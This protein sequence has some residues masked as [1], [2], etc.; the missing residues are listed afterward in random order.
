MSP[1]RFHSFLIP[2]LRTT[3]KTAWE[4]RTYYWNLRPEFHPS[5]PRVN[6][7]TSFGQAQEIIQRILTQNIMPFWH[8]RTI[9]HENGGYQLNHDVRGQWKGNT[10]K[11]LVTQTRML[12]Y[13]SRLANSP[14]KTQAHLDAAKHGFDFL[15]S[16]MWDNEDG[17][18]FWEV[19]SEGTAVTKSCKHLYG[20]S[21]ALYA[22]TEYAKASG[23]PSALP[24]AKQVFDLMET[25]AY[26]K[27]HGGYQEIFAS[28]W[29]DPPNPNEKSWDIPD[30]S[31]KTFNIHLHVLEA[32]TQYY[33]VTLDEKARD[34]LW[35][36][37]IL[38]SNTILRKRIGVCSNLHH[39][40]WTPFRGPQHDRVSYGHDLESI[41]MLIDAHQ[42]LG[43][44]STP[45]TDFFQTI[46]FNALQYGYD[47]QNGGFFTEGYFH[48]PADKREKFWWAQA[49]AILSALYMYR[50]TDQEIYANCF[51]Q[52]LNW[53]ESYQVDWEHGDW[54]AEI[55][56]NGKP[57]ADKAWAWKGAYHNGR[58]MIHALELLKDPCFAP[59]SFGILTVP[60]DHENPIQEKRERIAPIVAS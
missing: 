43:V 46:F 35:E 38:L 34:R 12:W 31:A 25:H 57:Y 3:L 56:E 19:N 42:T 32:Y 7:P 10:N 16:A 44:S 17:G 21:I 54:H 8:P 23:Q 49:E 47:S 5:L 30:P 11:S 27:T 2:Q 55:H 28:N 36:L 45:L 9:D 48:S 60:K 50:L 37:I 53:I 15:C 29:K 6:H 39:R 4:R 14:F 51:F 1:K 20:Q 33:R 24:C 13:F 41:W 58:A 26:D 18:F 22:L 59:Q 52:T 40:D